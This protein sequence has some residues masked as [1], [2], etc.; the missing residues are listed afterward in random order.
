MKD[1]CVFDLDGTLIPFDSF[2]HLVRKNLW[3]N[4]TLLGVA[5]ARRLGALDRAGFAE[6]AQ[7]ALRATLG[8]SRQVNAMIEALV[9]AIVP[10]RIALER[11]WRGR[12]ATTVLLSAS[13]AAYVVPLGSALGFDLSFGSCLKGGTFHHLHGEGKRAFVDEEFPA[14][15]WRRAF[16]M[17]DHPSDEALLVCFDEVMRV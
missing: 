11:H 14:S 4:P 5:M 16:A 15:Q 12:G 13:P 9:S 1:L 2:A 17:A 7:F 10:E 8:S 6:R 3:K